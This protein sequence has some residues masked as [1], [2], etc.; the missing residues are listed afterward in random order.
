MDVLQYAGQATLTGRDTT[1]LQHSH[2]E[3]ESARH[4]AQHLEVELEQRDQQ[5]EQSVAQVKKLMTV[6]HHLHDL[7]P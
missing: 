4:Y 1:Q 7:L 3:L 5:L 2:D 6:V